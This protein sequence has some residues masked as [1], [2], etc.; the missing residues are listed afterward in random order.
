[1]MIS[2]GEN[3]EEMKLQ[4][5]FRMFATFFKDFQVI[6]KDILEKQE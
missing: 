1:M 4:E 6:Y 3:P 5:F 2:Y